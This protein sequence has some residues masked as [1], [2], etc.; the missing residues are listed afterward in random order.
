MNNHASEEQRRQLVA[1]FRHSVVAELANPYLNHGE[2]ISSIREKANRTYEIPFSRKTTI[3]EGCI[4]K[5]A[6]SVSPL[7]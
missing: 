1:E 3:T 7:R 4:K 6:R 5:L 2:L